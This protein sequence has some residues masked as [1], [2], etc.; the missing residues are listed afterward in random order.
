MFFLG[1]LVNFD[2]GAIRPLADLWKLAHFSGGPV[3]LS[4]QK[5]DAN[6]RHNRQSDTTDKAQG[7]A[8]L[9][10]SFGVDQV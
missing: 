3:E 9:H 10:R 2:N 5:H 6:S 7:I 1:V 4:G 8:P